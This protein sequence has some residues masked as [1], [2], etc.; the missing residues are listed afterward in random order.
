MVPLPELFAFVVAAIVIIAIPGPSV[1]FVIGRALVLGKRGA[2][3]SVLGNAAGV[4]LQIIAVAAGLGALVAQS[5]VLFT[6]L[7]IV[8]AGVLVWLG[9]Q[10]I[11]HRHATADAD[12]AAIS[13]RPARLLRESFLVGIS[14]PKTIV[15]FV[16]ALPQFVVP[17]AG[18]PTLQ[19]LELGA[20]FLVLGIAGDSVYAIAA[21]AARD[22]F[23]SNPRRLS[24]MRASGGVA[25]IG[26]GGAMAITGSTT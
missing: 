10:A 23:A 6:V 9:I 14:N 19:M 20:I 8:G 24:G 5:V 12:V 2:L 16:A 26:L 22:W 4:A 1:L 18:S 17:G 25:L 7:K 15:F 3:L 13:T 21:G 11:R